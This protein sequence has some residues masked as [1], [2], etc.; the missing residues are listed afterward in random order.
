MKEG[1]GRWAI[2]MT[3]VA[4]ICGA[5]VADVETPI[6]EN[7]EPLTSSQSLIA[8]GASAQDLGISFYRVKK[9]AKAIVIDVLDDGTKKFGQL[10][11]YPT[12]PSIATRAT[13]KLDGHAAVKAQIADET[14]I[15]LGKKQWLEPDAN[16]Y[17][18]LLATVVNDSQLKSIFTSSCDSELCSEA[19]TT[20]KVISIPPISCRFML[21]KVGT[22]CVEGK[23]CVPSPTK[24]P[25]GK[26]LMLCPY[27]DW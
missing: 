16:P 25:T 9:S 19:T 1:F 13:I 7:Q 20:E 22:M 12:G 6:D 21:C 11:V 8:A 10:T 26:G 18:T 17:S 2:L 27:W 4:G 24:C 14:I 15:F 5:C 3:I 23:G